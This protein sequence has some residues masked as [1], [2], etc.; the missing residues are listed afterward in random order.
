MIGVKSYHGSRRRTC[1]WITS[2]LKI[3]PA[4]PAMV[5]G[6]RRPPR[7]KSGNASKALTGFVCT[8]RVTLGQVLTDRIEFTLRLLPKGY[9]ERVSAKG[10]RANQFAKCDLGPR[11]LPAALFVCPISIVLPQPQGPLLRRT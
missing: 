3:E 6:R 1:G 5:C 11:V 8:L 4:E 7:R 10:Q 2:F 9:P